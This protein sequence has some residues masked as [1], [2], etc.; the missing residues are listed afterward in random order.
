MPYT[1]TV[2]ATYV[3]N[4]IADTLTTAGVGITPPANVSS[5]KDAINSG[6][7]APAAFV[8][9]WLQKAT[10]PVVLFGNHGNVTI[11]GTGVG[12]YQ[13][14][15]TWNLTALCPR[16]Q[17][18]RFSTSGYISGTIAVFAMRLKYAGAVV[19][20]CTYLVN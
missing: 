17:V 4:S 5:M 14:V 3:A 13:T 12:V 19:A 20:S 6:S 15:G 8:D 7:L 11:T 2:A 18:L 9:G 10:E 16:P 1:P